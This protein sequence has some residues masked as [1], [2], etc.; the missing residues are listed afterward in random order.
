M[1]QYIQGCRDTSLKVAGLLAGALLALSPAQAQ[2]VTGVVVEVDAATPA[3]FVGLLV[4]DSLGNAVAKGQTSSTGTFGIDLPNAGF[5]TVRALRVGF[6]PTASIPTWVPSAGVATV[7]IQLEG[8][9]VAL[10]TVRVRQEGMCRSASGAGD[11]LLETWDQARAALLGVTSTPPDGRLDMESVAWIVARDLWPDTGTTQEIEQPRRVSANAFRSRGVGELLRRGFVRATGDSIEFDAPDAFVLLDPEFAASY[12]FWL[13]PGPVGHPTWIGLGVRPARAAAD[14]VTIQGVLWL[15]GNGALVRFDYRYVGLDKVLEAGLPGGRVE[16]LQ[17]PSGQWIVSRWMI[18]MPQ[19]V[20]EMQSTGP[21]TSA[22]EVATTRLARVVERGAFVSRVE[23]PDR[24]YLELGHQSLTLAL[25]AR[26]S[27]RQPLVG[28]RVVLPSED[29]EWIVDTSGA[30]HLERFRPGRHRFL[31]QTPLMRDFGLAPEPSDLMLLP[32]TTDRPTPLLVPAVAD[33]RRRLCPG[34]EAQAVAAGFIGTAA[35]AGAAL[36]VSRASDWEATRQPPVRRTAVVVDAVG[37]WRACGVPRATPLVL[38]TDHGGERQPVTR[39]RIPRTVDLALVGSRGASTF[40]VASA[41]PSPDRESDGARLIVHVLAARDSTPFPDAQVVLDDSLLARPNA[42]G[43]FRFSGQEEG[44]HAV[45]ARR[46]GFTPVTH[47]VVLALSE[48]RVDTVYLE[49]LPPLLSEVTIR[50]RALRVPTKYV[51]VIRRAASGWGT[52]FTREDIKGA[53]DLKSLL[54]SLPGVRVN[55]RSV[56]F[57]RC[58]GEL[59]PLMASAL[60]APSPRPLAE[61]ENKLGSPKVQVYIDGV[62]VTTVPLDQNSDAVTTAL[63]IV[64][65][66]EVEFMEVYRGVAQIPAEYLDDACAVIAIWT[67]VY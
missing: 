52:V 54:W 6:R 58:Q 26:G 18:R 38:W 47:S 48:P 63:R 32:D 16:F 2:R 42:Q 57:Q 66:S 45:S 17:L 1:N 29:Q 4:V 59:P 34:G 25:Q 36:Y 8:Q 50:G 40:S 43:E 62:R 46:L 39:F 27:A 24:Q 44:V 5:Y 60:L 56:V 13:E 11:A 67:R 19:A 9:R 14:R 3:G 35:P 28:T 55:D 53:Y 49:R 30:I 65:P 23:F 22:R 10:P 33:V 51:D 7:R 15:E 12:C 20:T 31:V 21:L 41:L 37:R 61:F 64:N